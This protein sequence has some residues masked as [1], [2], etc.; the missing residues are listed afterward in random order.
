[1]SY[2]GDAV[3]GADFTEESR[4]PDPHLLVRAYQHSGLTL[5]F[6]RSLLDGGFADMHHPGNWDLS[7]FTHAD[8]RPERRAAYEEVSQSLADA[9]KFMEVLGEKR[10]DELT[11]VEFFTSHEGLNLLYESAQTRQ[12]PR[13]AG[14]YNL[15]THLPWIGERTRQLDGAHVAFFSGIA[16]PIGVKVGP[17]A[18][19]S[20]VIRL[21]EVLNPANERGK[22]VLIGR[23]GAERVR[24]ALPPIVDA[25][26][27]A[28]RRC[29]WIADPMHGNGTKTTGGIKT[30]NF[31]AILDEIVGAFDAHA[32]L[33]TTRDEH[34]REVPVSRLGGVHFELTGEDVTECVGGAAGI[35]EDALTNN[36][37]SLCDPRLNYQQSL[38]L[39]F[40]VA[41]RLASVPRA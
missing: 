2:F 35:T 22:L 10:V 1:P 12:V 14:F 16:N 7:F 8:L 15:C 36:Y 18:D 28:G 4:R 26:A 41:E 23:M 29:L 17:T 24:D 32:S 40:L 31:D 34:G 25:V 33:G 6:I 11:R 9:L 38:E 39:A 19:P 30:R 13:R 3:N 21:T 27:R 20:E 37:A 5:N